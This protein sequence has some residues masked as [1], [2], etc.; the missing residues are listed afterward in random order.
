MDKI[1]RRSAL[2]R[3]EPFVGAWKIE[4][5]I[6][7]GARGDVTFEWTLDQQ[8]L[9]QRFEIPVPGAPDGLS[10]VALDT[11]GQAFTMHYFDSR[12]VVRLYAMTFS[13]GVW[14]LSRDAPDFTPLPF[15]QRFTGAFTDDADAIKGR[16]ETSEDGT[17]W[18]LDFELAY[19]RMPGG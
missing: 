10:I 17:A 5:S 18:K 14:T 6:A 3:L 16:W 1:T 11:D 12:G 9:L 7:P 4:A 8:F 15:H 13:E 19:T 2:D